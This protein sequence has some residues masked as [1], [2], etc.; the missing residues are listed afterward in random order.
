MKALLKNA[1]SYFEVSIPIFFI[2]SLRYWG[3]IVMKEQANFVNSKTITIDNPDTH[4]GR[5]VNE[6][7]EG[8]Y[9]TYVATWE[10][11]DASVHTDLGGF[12]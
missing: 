11:N 1:S 6:F 9:K 8:F 3:D 7:T 5:I 4:T 10:D 2:W 12:A